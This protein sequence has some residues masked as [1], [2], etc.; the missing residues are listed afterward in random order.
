MNMASSIGQYRHIYQATKAIVFGCHPH[1]GPSF[2]MFLHSFVRPNANAQ[3]FQAQCET[4]I[5]PILEMN[6]HFITITEDIFIPSFWE[7]QGVYRSLVLLTYWKKYQQNRIDAKVG[8]DNEAAIPLLGSETLWEIRSRQSDNYKKI[9]YEIQKLV[10]DIIWR[11]GDNPPPP[12]PN[13]HVQPQQ[14]Q[15]LPLQNPRPRRRGW[16]RWIGG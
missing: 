14:I 6:N 9:V 10:T 1:R 3:T 8:T 2:A 7:I 13:G 5:T 4:K 12:Y 16:L 11:N 15:P